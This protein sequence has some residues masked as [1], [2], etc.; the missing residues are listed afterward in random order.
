MRLR[1]RLTLAFVLLAILPLV[2][3]GAV[4]TKSG[5]DAALD[6]Q[7]TNQ[8]REARLASGEVA[9]FVDT[10]VRELTLMV[11]VKGIDQ[12]PREDKQRLLGEMLAWERQ[13]DDLV[14]LDSEGRE[15]AHVNLH[16]V[17]PVAELAS[18]A[19]RQEF[20][21]PLASRA[22][23]FGPMEIDTETAEPLMVVAV[24]SLDP[25]NGD[26]DGVLV[27]R[28][29]LKRMW[30]I[31]ARLGIAG[32]DTI[33]ITDPAGRVVAHGNPSVV[34]RGIATRLPDM[35]GRHT[36]I[37]GNPVLAA[38]VPLVAGG[39][40]FVVVA[41]RPIADALALPAATALA[42]VLVLA[43]A[44]VAAMGLVWLAGHTVIAPIQRLAGV[45]GAISAGDLSRRAGDTG[46][47]DEIGE[48]ARAFNAMTD[49][50]HDSLATLEAK[51][52]ERTTDLTQA[53]ARLVEAIE[54]VSEGFVLCDRD[55]CFVL[56]NQK[57]RDFYP[58]VAHLI[59]PGRPY[60]EV[61]EAAAQ[62][63][64]SDEAVVDPA[65]WVDRRMSLRAAQVPHVQH[66]ASGRW[67]LINEQRTDSG[68]MVAIY[69][70]ITELKSGEEALRAAKG[71]AEKAAQAKSEFLAAMSHELRTP[72]NAI[73]GFSDTMLNAVFGPVANERY[74]DYV[75]DIHGSGLHLLALIN[76]ILDLSKIEA[77]RLAVAQQAIDCPAVID[78]A[79]AMMKDLAAQGGLELE[80]AVESDLPAV[81][82]D[83]RRLLQVLLN[84]LSNAVKFT[85]EGGKVTVRATASADGVVV[86]VADTGIG[87][88]PADIPRAL[89]IF[90]QLD[91]M[92]S[93]RFP[94]SG[95]GLPLAR[96][97]VELHHGTLDIASVPGD[98]TVVTVRLPAAPAPVEHE[99]APVR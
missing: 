40:E 80:C 37:T 71:Q 97:L 99:A 46:R 38:R 79:V 89:E 15:Q 70:D 17:Y 74:L 53:Q 7:L 18:R 61:I 47:P 78:R 56:C 5:Y 64:L 43:A 50:L 32:A 54:S 20:Q 9:A 81:M 84:L 77:G 44:L 26:V 42:T 69:T 65:G 41:E 96:Q 95:L 63:G 88:A 8:R 51:V 98:G 59:H 82:G 23:W 45:A 92:R 60:R 30:E 86:E 34:L 55:D 1:L 10:L 11:R 85:P 19:D 62:R 68:Q 3:A 21:G 22:T 13:F 76:D 58:E 48:L 25:R 36:G 12:L 6:M 49:R 90:G 52:A 14:Y 72:L 24:P 39:R 91:S 75:R 93:R 94:G 87:I 16:D 2:I 67:L 57:F 4:V 35:D 29:R 83:E 73:I 31:V 27:A 66:L 28:M 33:Y